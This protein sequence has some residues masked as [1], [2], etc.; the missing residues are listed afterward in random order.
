MI[1]AGGPPDKSGAR[2]KDEEGVDIPLMMETVAL[3]KLIERFK[4]SRIA[5]VHAHRFD[6]AK[7]ATK[8]KD[9]PGVFVDPRGGFDKKIDPAFPMQVKK[10]QKA[11]RKA[12]KDADAA[13][14][15]FDTAKKALDAAQKVLDKTTKTADIESARKKLDAATKK[16][17]TA[18]E[19]L[20]AAK[21]D[22]A[23]HPFREAT[24]ITA[25]TPEGKKDDALALA[26]A[27]EVK[28]GSPGSV[29]GSHLGESGPAVAHYAE[30]AGK[31]EGRSLGDWG[32]E[33]GMTVITVEVR[34]YFE[35]G[36]DKGRA[37]ELQ[38]HNDALQKVFLE[39]N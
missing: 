30:S 6:D 34:H 31:P 29:P 26:I 20:E 33:H 19:K 18:Q 15:T 17:E 3:L 10:A 23:D 27:K 21:K 2:L 9:A 13:Q 11:A 14:K 37:Q 36:A 24:E 38:A 39:S 8:G 12:K 5:S 28:K 25:L 16:A 1:K 35:A 4:P 32:P 7:G 22:V